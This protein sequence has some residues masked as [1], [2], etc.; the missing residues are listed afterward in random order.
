MPSS[1]SRGANTS[2][3]S[4]SSSRSAS[5]SIT[6]SSRIWCLG[7]A[8]NSFSGGL[9]LGKDPAAY[10]TAFAAFTGLKADGAVLGLGAPFLF[11]IGVFILNFVIIYRGIS[12]G[13]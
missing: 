8:W 4:A 11:F 5:T 7:Y 12:R 1:A 2:A 3:S 10:A 9:D 13:I 6:S